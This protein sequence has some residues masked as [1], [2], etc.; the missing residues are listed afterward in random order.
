MPIN[1]IVLVSS[2]FITW[3]VFNW[4]TKVV[5][6]S[7]TTAF[8][9]IVIVMTLQITLGISPQQLWN[10]I[11]SFPKIIQEVFDK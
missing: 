4:T 11:L 1:L 6:T 7:V 3:L 9:I 10:Q 5:K 2:L 8:M